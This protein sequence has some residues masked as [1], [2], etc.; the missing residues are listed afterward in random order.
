MIGEHAIVLAAGLGTRMRPITDTMPKPLVPVSGKPLIGYAFDALKAAH[1][2]HVVVNVHYLPEQIEAW[3][4]AQATPRITISDERDAVLE[5]G[6]GI[7]RALPHLGDEPF[8]VMNSDSFWLEHGAPALV[9]LKEA[10]R[11][12]DMDCLLLVIPP[13]RTV[14]YDGIGDFERNLGGGLRRK[15]PD[16]QNLK[17]YIGGYLVHPRIFKN[18][19]PGKFSMNVLWDSAIAQDRLHSVVH[20]GWWLHVGTPDAIGLAESHMRNAR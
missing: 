13:E 9:R 15:R 16:S 5:T 17:A 11:D 20:D 19:P 7:V 2:K 6:G 1:V 4:A 10:W 12:A 14:G 3:C 8:F 18:A